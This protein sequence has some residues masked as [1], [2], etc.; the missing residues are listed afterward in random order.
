MCSCLLFFFFS[1]RSFSP[2]WPLAFLISH[3]RYKIFMFFFQRNNSPLCFISR[4]CSV[5]HVYVDI[6]IKSKEISGFIVVVNESYL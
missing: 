1:C 2:W 4:F 5:T 3:R 6:K